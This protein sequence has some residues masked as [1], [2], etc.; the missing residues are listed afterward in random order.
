MTSYL[1]DVDGTLTYPREKM[2][3][4]HVVPFLSWMADKKVFIVAGSDRKKVLEQLPASVLARCSGLFCCMANELWSNEERSL[5]WDFS[6]LHN[7][8]LVYR[9]GWKPPTEL[10]VDLSRSYLSSSYPK[11]RRAT[12]YIEERA[13]MLN[14]S[15]VGRTASREQR[16]HF[17]D[18]DQQEKE[19]ERIVKDL[20]SKHP[21]L[22]FRIGGQISIDI[23]PKNANKSQ[24]SKWVRENC[25]PDMIFFG[26]KC[27]KNGNDYD[28][29]KDIEK[30]EK[31]K[32]FCVKSP[33]ET[34]KLLMGNKK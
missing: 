30:H 4:E 1:F 34:L 13:G 26:D 15:I 32:V 19:R 28:I 18:W 17:S 20:S 31:G 10:I 27:D 29:V 5:I 23:Q 16:N 24:A 8:G 11:N 33:A 9:N 3:S 7:S 22:D 25:G 6:S 12:N 21:D 2:R 14:F